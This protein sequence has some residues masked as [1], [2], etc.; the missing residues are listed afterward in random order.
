[1]RAGLEL[2]KTRG[3]FR[4][5]GVRPPPIQS[6]YVPLG[7]TLAEFAVAPLVAQGMSN[8]GI[9]RELK[10]ANAVEQPGEGRGVD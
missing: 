8:K 5:V 1:M 3:M 4:E 6:G 9:G 2:E 10:C 7:L